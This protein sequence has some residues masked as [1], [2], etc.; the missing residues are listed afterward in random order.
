MNAG[1]RTPELSAL[2]VDSRMVTGIS[3][4]KGAHGNPEC[5]CDVQRLQVGNKSE[6]DGACKSLS[7]RGTEN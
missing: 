7:A 1:D 3:V 4:F 6:R 2:F 5:E